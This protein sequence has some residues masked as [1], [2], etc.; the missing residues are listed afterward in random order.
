MVDWGYIG[1]LGEQI[2][3]NAEAVMGWNP[4]R[5]PDEQY[6]AA[7][8]TWRQQADEARR[9]IMREA[10]VLDDAGQRNAAAALRTCA[11]WLTE[12]LGQVD[13]ETETACKYA[14]IE[15]YCALRN[16]AGGL[17]V[18]ALNHGALHGTGGEFRYTTHYGLT[19]V[20]D[21]PE[22]IIGLNGASRMVHELHAWDMRTYT[23]EDA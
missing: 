3:E 15:L 20:K 19:E 17:Y 18:V 6:P 16:V 10:V 22:E 4:V 12:T 7:R 2:R 5:H 14:A 8:E 13:A 23:E 11:D 21:G 9:T 1:S